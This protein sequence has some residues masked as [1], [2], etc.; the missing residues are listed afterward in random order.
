LRAEANSIA[1]PSAQESQLRGDVADFRY[2]KLVLATGAR[3]RFLPFPGWTLSN[4]MG[5]GGLDAMVR[6][7]L[8][9]RGKRV[10][11]AGTGPL[12]LAV[13]AHL[14][15]NGAEILAV[16]EQ[17]PLSQLARFAMS[18]LGEPA[19]LWQGAGYSR[20]F[21]PLRFKAGC[22]VVAAYGDDRVRR[23]TL[24]QGGRQW[25]V[26]CDYLACGFHLVPNNELPALLGCRIAEGLVATNEAMRT[27][28]DDIFCAGEPTG[29]GGVDVSLLE[30]QI[31]GLTAAGCEDQV[32][33]LIRRHRARL[34]FVKALAEGCRLDP[35]LRTMTT[36]ETLVCRCEDVR[37][38][39]L[40]HYAGWR[41]GKLHTRCGMGPCQGRICGS[42]TE[43]LLG[44]GADAPR[45]PVFPARISSLAPLTFET[46]NAEERLAVA[47]TSSNPKEKA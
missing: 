45:P 40:Q 6:G 19:K 23:V 22:W 42:A 11:V 30:G 7:G 37:F 1:A 24:R 43:F 17:A 44:W 2:D 28:V 41:D 12:L 29:I 25:D 3:E 32:K 10:I 14:A 26:E 16:C 27:S 5:A 38:G 4:V 46:A 20:A 21:M 36:A 33:S 31:A 13:S 15:K 35:Q 47:A 9:I 34:G 18:M 39:A 8:R